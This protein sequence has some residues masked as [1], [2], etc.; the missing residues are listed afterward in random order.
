M[1]L[2]T[3]RVVLRGTIASAASGYLSLRHPASAEDQGSLPVVE[4]LYGPIR[5]VRE[6][7]VA[8]FRGIPFAKPPIGS[9]RFQPPE[10]PQHWSEIRD[11]T[12]FGPIAPQ[13]KS[14]L[15]RVMGDF[16]LP[17]SEDC[18]TLNIWSP[19][20]T[21]TPA[22]V[23]V[24]IHGGGQTSGSGRLDWYSGWHLAQNGGIVVVTIN[25]RVGPLGFMYLPGIAE[26]NMN[27]L[28]QVAAFEWVRDNISRFG[29]NPQLVTLAGQSGGG[30]SIAVHLAN[31][32]H[33]KLFHRAIVQSPAIG[34]PPDSP[35]SAEATAHQY[36]AILKLDRTSDIRRVPVNVLLD[37]FVELNRRAKSSGQQALP[38]GAVDDGRVYHGDPVKQIVAGAGADKD[39][40]IG[41]TRDEA[42][43]RFAFDDEVLNADDAKV[44]QRFASVFGQNV[45]EY[46]DEFRRMW[47]D[48]T[49]YWL[50]VHL[51]TEFEY[52]RKTLA[53][54]EAR[55]SS[56]R[57]AFLYRFDWQSPTKRFGACHC[58]ELPFTFANFE[59]WSNA[60]M[61]AN[62]D[63]A[64]IK[65]LS[66][67]MNRAWIEFIKNGTPNHAAMAPWAPYK[68][69][70]R[71]TLR[72]D[73]IVEPVGDLAGVAWR[74]PWPAY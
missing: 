65:T 1:G 45:D 39:L 26:G 27:V 60:P 12:K 25:Y 52:L 15:A 62:A 20:L 4:T 37:A 41:T 21:G 54:V 22:P 66:H 16:D 6:G 63:P 68:S 43:A 50:L 44:H 35:D 40:M 29:G 34:T 67:I 48:A 61:L 31:P 72:F 49:P 30:R 9:L 71:T 38:F 2:L 23:M 74:R 24:W 51:E 17:Q 57:P 59:N 19:V 13:G 47:A 46:L 58:L 64:E 14:R 56:E 32:Q 7:G 3:R 18:L 55:A 5:G 53:I 70:R 10:R 11:A 73:S 36:L 8:V 28:D 33:R 69:D 42:A